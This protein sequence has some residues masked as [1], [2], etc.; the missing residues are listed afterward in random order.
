MQAMLTA[1]FPRR[2][3]PSYT[4][5][6]T[7][8]CKFENPNQLSAAHRTRCLCRFSPT[9]IEPLVAQI[10]ALSRDGGQ[11]N[12]KIGEHEYP[13]F[14]QVAI[15]GESERSD[16]LPDEQPF[17]NTLRAAAAPLRIHLA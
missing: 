15:D 2:C 12:K 8:S 17:R 10:N 13:V 7:A 11:E 9:F 3:S 5:T 4:V 6:N 14:H 1:I 16:Q